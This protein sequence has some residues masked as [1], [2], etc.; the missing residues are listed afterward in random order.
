MLLLS[1]IREERECLLEGLAKRKFIDAAPTLDKIV[2][3]DDERKSSQT[4]LDQLLSEQ[5][6]LS[7][8]IGD[9]FKSGK[10]EEAN[11]VLRLRSSGYTG[12]RARA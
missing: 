12:I 6:S 4:Q 2:A 3:L 9:L 7:K 10:A 5:K 1:T 8:E 11:V